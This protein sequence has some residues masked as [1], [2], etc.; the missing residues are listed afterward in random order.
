MINSII[1]LFSFLFCRLHNLNDLISYMNF[2]SSFVL[3]GD[4]CKFSHQ[5]I[6]LTKSTVSSGSRLVFAA[7]I[8]SN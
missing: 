5:T 4:K 8:H 2:C 3:Q 6:P 1:F 7:L